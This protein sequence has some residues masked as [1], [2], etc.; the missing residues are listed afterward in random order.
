MTSSNLVRWAGLAAILGAA[1]F[2]IVDL[3]VPLVSDFEASLSEEATSFGWHLQSALSLI[4]G[5]LVLLGLVGL[6]SHRPEAMGV[7]GLIAFLITFFG[8]VLTQGATWDQAF[9]QP[10]LAVAAP[11]LLEADPPGPI[12]FGL[13]LSYGLVNLGWLLFAV[14]ALRARVFPRPASL[15]LIVGSLGGLL[16]LTLA[17]APPG[18]VLLYVGIVFDILFFG[19]IAWMGLI[20]FTGRGASAEQPSRVR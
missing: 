6:Y 19:A 4:A 9:T 11:E 2:I 13:L 8:A 10:A 15:L 5:P 12:I 17:G 16:S 18:G 1:L 14:A 7:F 20:V 3:T